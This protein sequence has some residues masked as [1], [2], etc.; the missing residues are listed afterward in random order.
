MDLF[1]FLKIQSLILERK[2]EPEWEGQREEEEKRISQADTT[3]SVEPDS[4]L[5]PTTP[6]IKTWAKTNCATQLPQY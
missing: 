6:Q 4:G 3:L 1:I 2:R 5:K